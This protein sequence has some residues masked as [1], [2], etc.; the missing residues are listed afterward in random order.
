[1]QGVLKL[2]SKT[3]KLEK[4]LIS[5]NRPGVVILT[6]FVLI[7]LL[8]SI[9]LAFSYQNLSSVNHH[10]E[11]AVIKNVQ[12]NELTHRLSR[13]ASGHLLILSQCWMRLML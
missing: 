3:Y 9:V 11:E 8:V 12:K 2:G 4:Q 13:L 1:M 10:V 7:L 5:M 6:G